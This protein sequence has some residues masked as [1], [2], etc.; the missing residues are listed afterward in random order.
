M[1]LYQTMGLII[2][3]AAVVVVDLCSS[4][5]EQLSTG[6]LFFVGF[7]FLASFKKLLKERFYKMSD[8]GC[9]Y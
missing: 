6:S 7:H 9:Q 5:K 4:K 2:I 8:T 1:R 3:C